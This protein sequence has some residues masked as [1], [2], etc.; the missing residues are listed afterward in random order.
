MPC[1]S[2]TC[3]SG[4]SERVPSSLSAT[5]V[6]RFVSLTSLPG[7]PSSVVR[8]KGGGGGGEEHEKG[9]SPCDMW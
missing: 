1:L 7:D 6:P 2:L 8:G 4:E 5:H 3:A 9:K